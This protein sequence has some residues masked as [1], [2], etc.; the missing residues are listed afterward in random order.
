MLASDTFFNDYFFNDYCRGV[1]VPATN[2]GDT[3]WTYSAALQGR[4]GLLRR[5]P[6]RIGAFEQ[7]IACSAR[8]SRQIASAPADAHDGH[9]Q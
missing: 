7:E 8:A 6:E 4:S 9:N 1:W 5:D 2:A 3:K